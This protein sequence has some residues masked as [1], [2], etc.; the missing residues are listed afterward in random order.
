MMPLAAAPVYGAWTGGMKRR[1]W[2]ERRREEN[3][4]TA[5]RAG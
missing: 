4:R 1:Q 2:T 5:L 3:P